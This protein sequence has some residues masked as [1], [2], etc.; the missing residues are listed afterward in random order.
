MNFVTSDIHFSH[1][2]II[3]YC[4]RPF[5]NSFEMDDYIISIWN[6]TVSQDDNIY[7]LGDF[8]FSRSLE[9]IEKYVNRL[10]GYKILIL[11]NH[12]KFSMDEYKLCGF[13]EVYEGF[14]ER[15]IHNRHWI[16]CHFQMAHW[17]CSH[18][19]SFHLFG[20]EHWKQQYEPKHSIYKEL[21]FS[22]RKYNVCMD[23]NNF[24]P[25]NLL[26]LIKILDKREI[27]IP[28]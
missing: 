7:I 5:K 14:I 1:Q 18:K 4:N 19:G 27:N 8:M 11:G 24:K 26:D 28:Y 2:N 25:V 21:C 12:D 16:M 15:N 22:E 10:N 13:N 17:N 3:K 23:A 9:N 6:K 20:H